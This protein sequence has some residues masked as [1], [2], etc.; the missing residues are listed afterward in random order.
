MINY[1]SAKKVA[2]KKKTFITGAL[3]LILAGFISRIIGFVFRIYLSNL[4]GAEGIGLYQLVVPVYTLII[5]TLTSGVS[6][7]VSKIIAEQVALGNLINI[8]RIT[9]VSLVVVF[10]AGMGISLLM[11]LNIDFIVNYVLKDGRTY[12][13]ILYMIPCIPFVAAACAIKGYFYG[14]QEV[15]PTAVSQVV[16]QLV[17]IAII[18]G[19]ATFFLDVGLGAACALATIGTAFGE[20]SNLLVLS[21]YYKYKKYPHIQP[22]SKQGLIQKRQLVKKVISF[23]VPISINRFIISVLAA[24]E[25]ILIPQRLLAGGLDYIHCMEEF[26]KLTGM[27]MPLIT[28]PALVTNSLSTTLV[29]AIAASISLKDYYKANFRIS[30]S[31]QITMVLG[32]IFT[33]LFACYPNEICDLIY[34]RQ[35]VGNTLLLLSWTCVLAY[36]QQILMSTL[37]GLGK[38]GMLLTNSLIGSSIRILCVYFLMPKYGL[39]SYI[40]AMVFSNLIVCILN[41]SVVMR[42]TG[43]ALDIR[44]WLVLPG[45]VTVFMIWSGKYI[46]SAL[47]FMEISAALHTLLAVAVYILAGL[48]LMTVVGVI[49]KNE[50]MQI[51]GVKRKGRT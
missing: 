6:V 39:V 46:Y 38:Q 26:G 14:I 43:M 40:A 15:T 29:P 47:N 9:R 11:Y 28:F 49:D 19:L 1:T 41:F 17:K 42:C 48:G 25:V 18:M 44:R 12:N 5:L 33:A 27:A 10:M 35:N 31:I 37:N 45:I 2:M 22:K 16:E 7:A 30:K 34:P 36:L 4:I 24:I 32:F 3:I 8:K 23:S 20:M 13:S 21:V 50:I 51:F